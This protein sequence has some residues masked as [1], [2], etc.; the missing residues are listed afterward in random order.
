MNMFIWSTLKKHLKIWRLNQLNKE[1]YKV[2]ISK[3]LKTMTLKKKVTSAPAHRII[4]VPP[5]KNPDNYVNC[6]TVSENANWAYKLKG[7]ERKAD[8]MN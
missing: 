4:N 1:T 5:L 2:I 8:E 3:W 7:V 6:K